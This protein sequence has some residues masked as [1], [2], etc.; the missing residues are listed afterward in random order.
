MTRAG[1]DGRHI[2]GSLFRVLVWR[3]RGS[4]GSLSAVS[5]IADTIAGA[6]THSDAEIANGLPV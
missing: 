3:W 1:C 6:L 4:Q 2:I 5:L